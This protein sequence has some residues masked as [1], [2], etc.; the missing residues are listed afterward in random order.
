MID[1]IKNFG[2]CRV[3]AVSPILKLAEPLYN[4]DKIAA[5]I[6]QLEKK[7]VEIVCFPELALTGYTCEDLFH[8]QYLWEDVLK[9]LSYILRT[10]QHSPLIASFGLPI[11][12]DDGKLYNCAITIRQGQ[13]LGIY[14]KKYLPNYNEF[15]EMR[16]FTSG[17]NSKATFTFMEKVYP[18][19]DS[20]FNIIDGV[21]RY[22]IGVSICEDDWAPHQNSIDLALSGATI[23]L[24]LSASNELVSKSIYRKDLIQQLSGRTNSIYIYASTGANESVK[25]T[26]FG[27]HCFIYENG[28]LIAE[29]KRF[30]LDEDSVII[31]DVDLQKIEHER[32][33][34]TTFGVSKPKNAI[35]VMNFND[36]KTKPFSE[37]LRTYN[38]NPFLNSQGLLDKERS[39]EIFEILSTGL[40]KTMRDT[41]I[42]KF[43]M[44]LSGGMDSTLVSLIAR[45]ALIKLK[46]PTTDLI[47]IS[48]PGFGTSQ[49]TKNQSENLAKILGSTFFE[50]D[51][52]K[53]VSQH[54]ADIQHPDGL[55][56][57]TYENAQ[58]RERT[59]II[60]DMANKHNGMMVGSSSLSE[61]AC[62]F[63]TFGGDSISHVNPIGSCPKS[64]SRH[65][66]QFYADNH[67]EFNDILKQV[68]ETK[69]SPELL[70]N[71]DGKEIIQSSEAF[72]GDY[73][74]IDF[75]LYHQIKNGFS[76]EKI[77]F[78]LKHVYKNTD[79]EKYTPTYLDEVVDRYFNR[80]Y[81]NQFKR[82]MMP[83]SFKIGV[84]LSPRSDWRM[85]DLVKYQRR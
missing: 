37:L 83:Q 23:L 19:Q 27:G 61:I 16:F 46:K 28:T 70:P 31:T 81:K 45:E 49:R 78:L 71:P 65:L 75:I 35:Q 32:T 84:S 48:M 51:I 58:A 18:L 30:L 66:I 4:A 74:I 3:A 63:A 67:L 47:T 34:N 80:F 36:S 56:D 79:N 15:Y 82:T 42:H 9:G 39:E 60:L 62:G 17:I 14:P 21:K 57:I 38:A 40:A 44:G 2:Y 54:F 7:Q 85:P 13:I 33:V 64:L 12:A 55:Y 8:Q 11:K 10:T 69:I 6:K 24:N 73:N 29:N 59:Q 72:L 25:D 77:K 53:A 22:G 52:K 1:V 43:V 26:V 20:V 5:L 76:K 50:I 41:G 68:L